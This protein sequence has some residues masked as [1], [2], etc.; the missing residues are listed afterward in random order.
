MKVESPILHKAWWVL[1]NLILLSELILFWELIQLDDISLTS[2]IL[3]RR[4]LKWD[5]SGYWGILCNSFKFASLFLLN[6][7]EAINI[8]NYA[9]EYYDM[10]YSSGDKRRSLCIFLSGL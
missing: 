7:K 3:S 10:L 1:R 9:V 4:L 5:L 6:N 2:S 8:L